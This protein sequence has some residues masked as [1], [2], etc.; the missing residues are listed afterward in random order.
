[1]KLYKDWTDSVHII[2]KYTNYSKEY[3]YRKKLSKEKNYE[4]NITF[5]ISNIKTKL[6]QLA[7]NHFKAFFINIENEIH[8]CKL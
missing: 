3:R 6:A 8:A 7:Y 4:Q 2:D 5:I 1:M